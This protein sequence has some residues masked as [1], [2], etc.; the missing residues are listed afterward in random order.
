MGIG[1]AFESFLAPA[2]IQSLKNIVG[3]GLKTAEKFYDVEV[4]FRRRNSTTGRYLD[5]GD[6]VQLITLDFGLREVRATQ[7][8]PLTSRKSDGDLKLWEGDY[9]PEVGDRFT[10]KGQVVEITAVY[11]AQN[12]QVTCEVSLAQS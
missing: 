11:P 8:T 10:H 4:Q 12:F 3:Q 2:Q 5:N 7:G 6:P 1:D 9:N